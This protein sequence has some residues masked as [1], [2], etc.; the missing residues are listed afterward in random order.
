MRGFR[1]DSYGDAFADVYDEW[2]ADVTDLDATVAFVAALAGPDGSV[3]ELGVGTGRLAVPIAARAGRVVGVDTSRR[4]LEELARSDVDR[5]VTTVHGDMVDDL[6]DGPF[7]VVLAAYN[8]V[9]NLTSAERQQACFDQVA[10]RLAPGGR[11]VVEAF[12]PD[13]ADGGD[14]GD[15]GARGGGTHVAPHVAPDWTTHAEPAPPRARMR[16]LSRP[17]LAGFAALVLLVG[18]AAL[19]GLVLAGDPH[20]LDLA[21]IEAAQSLRASHPTFARAMTDASALGSTTVL[22]LVV[23]LAVGHLVLS[24]HRLLGLVV[25]VSALGGSTL[26]T[27]LKVAVGRVRP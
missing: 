26:V 1:S 18:F 3:L 19:A 21:A 10:A 5:T 8:T 9:F 4:M 25:A 6:P 27:A 14:G 13:T 2:Y 11:F 7:D 20:A 24:G 23:V 16:A 17:L 22:T 15:G 12:V